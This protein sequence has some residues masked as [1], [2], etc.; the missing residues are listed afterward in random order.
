[1]KRGALSSHDEPRP[2]KP[3]WGWNRTVSARSGRRGSSCRR[4]WGRRGR[5]LRRRRGRGRCRS[6]R[7][8]GCAGLL[9]CLGCIPLLIH[10][11]IC[12]I[13]TIRCIRI[14]S[15]VILCVLGSIVRRC[16][17]SGSRR[18]WRCNSSRS[19]GRVDIAVIVILVMTVVVVP[20]VGAALLAR[21]LAIPTSSATTAVAAW[22][23]ALEVLKLL[24]DIS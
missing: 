6:T 15:A 7:R 19:C 18:R 10:L 13:S 20:V 22:R 14:G 16:C 4:W 3:W 12:L 2:S 24:S 17:R 9:S 21:A 1:M 5:G 23:A 11:H 8:S